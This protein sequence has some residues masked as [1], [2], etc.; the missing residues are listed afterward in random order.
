MPTPIH[1][2]RRV[3]SKTAGLP[4]GTLV[5]TGES[6]AEV[7]TITVLMY[8]DGHCEERVLP[9]LEAI[10]N[11]PA[12]GV[13]WLNVDGLH[14]VDVIEAIGR[15]FGVHPLTMEDI[16]NVGQ[17]PKLEDF[18]DHLYVVAQMLTVHNGGRVMAEQISLVIGAGTLLTFQE[19]AG[20]PF[21]PVRER[22]RNGKGRIR[23]MGADYLAYALLDTIVDHYFLLLERLDD[24]TEEIEASIAGAPQPNTLHD[25]HAL[26][27]QLILVRKA[28]WPLRDVVSG[29]ERGASPLF[30]D[31]TRVYLRDLYDHTVRTIDTVETLRDLLA[32]LLDLYVSNLTRR[33]NETMKVLTIIATIFLPLTLITSIY[34][35]NFRFMPELAWRWG[36]FA[37]LAGMGVIGAAMLIYFRKRKWL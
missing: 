16:V 29:L 21:E 23:T 13:M 34:G 26:K 2:A 22:I 6:T 7:P 37:V 10:P 3:R 28:V 31:A 4:P 19:H 32:S 9:G 24:T 12:G 25:L 11:P 33:L 35:M 20:D 17:R 5:H 8:G 30:Q 36:Y 27:R 14:R 1:R 15:R 18:R